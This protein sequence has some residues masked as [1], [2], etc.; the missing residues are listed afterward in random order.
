M[1]YQENHKNQWRSTKKKSLE[2][3]QYPHFGQKKIEKNHNNTAKKS[4]SLNMI[5][6]LRHRSITKTS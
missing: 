2:I 3:A 1:K 4:K 6:V 5:K